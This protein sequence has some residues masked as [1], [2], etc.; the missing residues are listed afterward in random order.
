MSRTSFPPL[1]QFPF[2]RVLVSQ[3]HFKPLPV[4]PLTDAGMRAAP[5]ET[6]HADR[7][8][9]SL[10]RS[11][12]F[13]QEQHKETLQKLHAEIDHLRREN[14]ELLYRR[15][16]EPAKLRGKGLEAKQVMKAPA[17][18][19]E[20]HTGGSMQERAL[21]PR[22]SQE[23]DLSNSFEER[24]LPKHGHQFFSRENVGTLSNEA[25][26]TSLQ[27]EPGLQHQR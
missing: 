1:R 5:E 18:G 10:E 8:V 19:G 24:K 15:I 21:E 9:T 16:M 22:P 26:F 2:P 27:A 23:N 3:Q 12:Q 7:R 6:G 14:K 17:K 4:M 20:A 25:G 13:L 11:I